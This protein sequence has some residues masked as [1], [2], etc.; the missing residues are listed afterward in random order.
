MEFIAMLYSIACVRLST[1]NSPVGG[2]IVRLVLSGALIEPASI[3]AKA[4]SLSATRSGFIQEAATSRTPALV[5]GQRVGCGVGI[6]IFMGRLRDEK[7]R[8][9]RMS[10]RLTGC[11]REGPKESNL[12]RAFTANR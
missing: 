3:F 9:A 1:G 6:L 11:S 7:A 2:A 8:I 5:L 4:A 10:L 12:V